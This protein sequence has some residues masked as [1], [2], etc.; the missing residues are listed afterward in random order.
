MGQLE[1]LTQLEALLRKRKT[2]GDPQNSYS[3]KLL[4][5]GKDRILRKLGEES[6]ETIIAAKNTNKD[7]LIAEC[8]DLVF[9]L[10][11]LLV[12]EDISFSNIVS[13]LESRH[14]K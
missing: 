4:R 10:L 5:Q 14:Q 3:A 6:A 12:H 1:F 11:V 9:H 8:S 2:E 13:E 7:E